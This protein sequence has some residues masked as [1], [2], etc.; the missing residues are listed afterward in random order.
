LTVSNTGVDDVYTV[1]IDGVSY[2]ATATGSTV[3]PSV[4]VTQLIDDI[5]MMQEQ[6]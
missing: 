3:T 6:G 2:S 5:I 1:I 4:L